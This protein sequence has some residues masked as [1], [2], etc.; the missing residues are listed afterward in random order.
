VNKLQLGGSFPCDMQ[1]SILTTWPLCD[2]H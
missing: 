2:C 1:W